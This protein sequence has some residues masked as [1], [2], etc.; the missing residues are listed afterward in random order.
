[1]TWTPCLLMLLLSPG[2][3]VSAKNKNVMKMPLLFRLVGLCVLSLMTSATWAASNVSFSQEAETVEAYDF[4]EVTVRVDKP[5]AR[6]P[7]LD[8]T[9]TGSFSKA[10][11]AERKSVEGFCDS[12]D[13]SVFRIRF[14]PASPGDYIYSATYRQGTTEAMHSGT[15]KASASQRKGPIRVDPNY[16]WHFLWEGTGE[17]YYFNG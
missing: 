16:P 10:D 1:M 7:F 4:V 11:G 9:V 15:F 17:H 14:M 8:A 2:T 12:S 6:N 3:T 5:E 13:G